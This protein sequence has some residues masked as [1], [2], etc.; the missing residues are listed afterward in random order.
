MTTPCLITLE[1]GEGAGKSSVLAA[2][3]TVLDAHGIAHIC[4]REPG[5]SPLAESIRALMLDPQY[6]S[7]NAIT[8]A[9]L[10]FAAR[11]DHVA[12]TVRPA[13]ANGQW[14]ISDRFVDASYAYQGGGRGLP[15]ATLDT[16]SAWALDGVQPAFTLLLDVP[17]DVGLARAQARSQPDRIE[18][19]Q[20]SFFERVRAAYLARAAADPLRFCVIDAAAAQPVVA[21]AARSAL[22]QFLSR[23]Q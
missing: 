19:E 22:T 6:R 5:G 15:S 13:L 2:L 14:V 1:G 21:I 11:A 16:L 18:R 12:N 23:W 4:T 8:E 3:R 20:S 7:M 9:L 10:V 17:V